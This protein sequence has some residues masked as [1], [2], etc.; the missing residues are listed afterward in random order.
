[1]KRLSDLNLDLLGRRA[2]LISVA[3]V[4]VILLVWWFAWMSPQGAKLTSVNAEATTKQ[5]QLTSLEQVL[6]Q[7]EHDAVLA[8]EEQKYLN[9]FTAAVPSLPEAGPL[10]TELFNLS[11]RTGVALGSL[12]DDTTAAPA[13]GS[14]LS[15]IPLSIS[16]TGPHDH[17]NAF[18]QGLYS[19]TRLVTVQTVSPSP[20]TGAGSSGAPLSVLTND[21]TPYSMAISATAYFSP[22]IG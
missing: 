10:T 6:Q 21:K 17:C 14:L 5:Q 20:Q 12:A 22:E 18:L 3:A 8:K 2:V 7:S 11:K 4:V 19:L 16:I 13:T 15:T 9:K 1:M